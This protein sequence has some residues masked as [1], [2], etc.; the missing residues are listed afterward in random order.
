MLVAGLLA[1][2]LNGLPNKLGLMIASLVGVGVGVAL[3]WIQNETASPTWR[4][5]DAKSEE[6]GR[7]RMNE[8]LPIFGM[9][10]VTFGTRY[11]PMAVLRRFTLPQPIQ[12]GLTFVPPVVLMAIVAP[13]MLSPT[14]HTIDFS[15]GNAYL[16][17][18]L[19]SFVIALARQEPAADHCRAG[20]GIFLLWRMVL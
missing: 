2:L 20:M 18:G 5:G 1:V 15:L 7:R 3:D 19:A 12:R 13:A 9:T 8:A 10:A 11:L 14:S 6:D 16:W 4:H 17:A